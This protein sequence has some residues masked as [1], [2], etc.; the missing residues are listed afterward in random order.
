MSKTSTFSKIETI[1]WATDFSNESRFCLPY[2]KIFSSALK[3]K[4]HAL[5]VLPKF[6][7]WVYETAFASDEELLKTIEK[8]REHSIEKII[9]TSKQSNVTFEPHFIE[10]RITSEEIIKFAGGK[11]VDLIFA[12]RRGIS[13]IE[14]ILIG[15]T[16]SRLIRN[17][18]IPVLVIPQNRQVSKIEKILCP[19]DLSESSTMELEYA[20]SLSRQLQAKLEVIHVAEFFSYKIPVFK[21]D[22]LIDKISEKI[23]KIAGENKYKIE[24]IIYETGEPAKK[25]IEVAKAN[26][27]DIITMATHQRKG[28]EK[29]FLGSISEKVIMYSDI[30]VLILPPL[31]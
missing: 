28:L 30:P 22:L 16:T 18:D 26:K 21:K 2:I 9:D 19:I 5:Y 6:S 15:S 11:K 14:E 1:L 7:D 31:A 17:S 27:T 23:Q 20:I 25:I 4:N 13:E 8:T 12:G 24:N 29:F 10:G 3:T